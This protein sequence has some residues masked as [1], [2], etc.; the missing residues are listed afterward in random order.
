MAGVSAISRM[1]QQQQRGRIRGLNPVEEG[2]RIRQTDEDQREVEA[3]EGG[4]DW[5]KDS[6]ADRSAALP[7]LKSASFAIGQNARI[8]DAAK[9]RDEASAPIPG[10]SSSRLSLHCEYWRS[11]SSK[12]ISTF[13]CE[14]SWENT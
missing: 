11:L 4:C 10:S 14:K 8:T 6:V 2:T 5:A 12:K 9:P 3:Q 7:P 13:Q 1:L